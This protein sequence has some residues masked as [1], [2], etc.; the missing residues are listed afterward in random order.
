MIILR[1]FLDIVIREELGGLGER[2]S[3][4]AYLRIFYTALSA[5]VM[6]TANNNL[7]KSSCH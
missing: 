7:I 6:Y 4:R 3:L 2:I 1:L 5:F